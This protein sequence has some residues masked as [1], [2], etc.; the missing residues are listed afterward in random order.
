MTG[1]RQ[2]P[3]VKRGGVHVSLSAAQLAKIGSTD[4]VEKSRQI[5]NKALA[6]LQKEG[7][8][9]IPEFYH[10]WYAYYA[11]SAPDLVRSI[12]ILESNK[13]PFS[14]DRCFELYNH[15][16]SHQRE[17]KLVED[18]GHRIQRVLS[19]VIRLLDASGVET[20]RFSAALTDFSGQM[21]DEETSIF[22]LRAIIDEVVLETRKVI[23]QNKQLSTALDTTV[24]EVKELKENL[25]SVRKEAMTDPLTNIAN[26]KAFDAR[27]RADSIQS[28]EDGQPM[29]LIMLDIDHFK[30][31]NDTYGHQ[32]GDKVI[33]LVAKTLVDCVKGQ[34][35][36]ARF[37]G[38]EF[39]IILPRTHLKNAVTLADDI[40]NRI[41]GKALSSKTTGESYGTVTLSLGIAQ[42]RHGESLSS[43]IE[44]ADQALYVAKRNGRNRVIADPE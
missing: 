1:R 11:E 24:T 26:R 15:F 21:I 12:Q 18:A 39:S 2:G 13:M 23:D 38:E 19:E 30:K 25:D 8:P 37:G 33:Q 35:M 4:S 44:R 32:V 3:Q 27:L 6:R 22:Q 14:E 36:A 20:T 28:M 29:C 16:L 41:A 43:L 9:G 42:F 7:L 17:R 5:A 31:I 10:L 40:R 34:D